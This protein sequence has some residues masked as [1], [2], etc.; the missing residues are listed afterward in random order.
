MPSWECFR[1]L[2]TLCFGP[3]VRG[4]RLSELARL[5]FTST[6]QD[7]TERFNA[8]LCHAHSL[9]CPQKAELFVGSLTDHIRIDVELREPRDLQRAMYLA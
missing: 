6:I 1:E 5:L 2:C 8:V 4:T 7:Y 3:T 9:S